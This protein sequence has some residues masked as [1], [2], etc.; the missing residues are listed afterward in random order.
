MPKAA[1]ALRR[2][3]G[4]HPPAIEVAPPEVAPPAA[5][6]LRCNSSPDLEQSLLGGDLP[7]VYAGLSLGNSDMVRML[8]T[9]DL[10]KV[11]ALSLF[12]TGEKVYTL[13]NRICGE[14]L[15]ALYSAV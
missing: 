6:V 15:I 5:R 7:Q 1:L 8:A 3:E 4:A 12:G 14:L 2:L 11:T 10:R 9:R 13:F